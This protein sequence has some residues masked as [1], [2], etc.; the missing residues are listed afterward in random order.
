MPFFHE[1]ALSP[2]VTESSIIPL[3]RQLRRPVLI[4]SPIIPAEVL[5]GRIIV[6]SHIPLFTKASHPRNSSY[7]IITVLISIRGTIPASVLHFNADPHPCSSNGSRYP[8]QGR[9]PQSAIP[10]QGRGQGA[11]QVTHTP[12]QRPHTRHQVYQFALHARVASATRPK[13]RF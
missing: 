2:F 12:H 6:V 3:E 1:L 10:P 5:T 13:R 8:F 11:G 4:I 9:S 7:T